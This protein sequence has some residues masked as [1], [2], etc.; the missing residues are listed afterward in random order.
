MFTYRLLKKYNIF[1]YNDTGMVPNHPNHQLL[2]DEK[3]VKR[4]GY[5]VSKQ[6]S[7]PPHHQNGSHNGGQ[8]GG[9]N[10]HSHSHALQSHGGM[11]HSSE[12]HLHNSSD[13]HR[14]VNSAI[15]GGLHSPPVQGTGTAV[16]RKPFFIT[17]HAAA[18]PIHLPPPPPM[19]F[20]PSQPLSENFRKDD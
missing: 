13:E 17:G 9:H 19:T 18:P 3:L 2:L 10:G 1:H 7:S 4:N 16:A 5:S 15:L 6:A 14:F 11:I 8:S 12:Q 20:T